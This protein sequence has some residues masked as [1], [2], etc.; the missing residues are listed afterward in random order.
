VPRELST[1]DS[2]ASLS[3]AAAAV[4]VFVAAGAVLMLE[5]LAARLMAP[6]VG[7]SLNTYTG[8]IGTVLGGIAVGAWIGGRMADRIPP[9][10]LLSPIL[11]IG[12]L[13]VMTAAPLVTAFGEHLHSASLKAIIALSAVTVLLPALV[14]STVTPIVVKMQLRD[15]STTG[16]VVGRLS[17]FA[18]AG[19]LVGTFGTGFILAERVH[20]R[21]TLTSAG[22]VLVVLGAVVAWR[23]TRHLVRPVAVILVVGAAAAAAGAAAA[24]HGPCKVESGYFCIWVQ[25]GSPDSRRTL[26]LD[27]LTHSSVDVDDPRYLGLPYTRVLVG[28]VGARAGSERPLTMLHIGGGAFAV[29]RYFAATRRGSINNVIEIDPAVVDTARSDFGVRTGPRLRVAVGDA[30]VLIRRERHGT[31]DFVIGDAFSSRSA[32]WHLTTEQFLRQVRALLRPD[33]TY[34]MN[35]IDRRARFVRAEAATL[36]K[37]FP[38]VALLELPGSDNHV[39]M[40]ATTPIDAA[41]VS[42]ASAKLGVPI[43]VVEEAALRQLIGDAKPLEDDFAPVDQLLQR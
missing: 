28:A 4:V 10:R 17:G 38:H 11:I 40:G 30:R 34:L 37:V 41:A 9:R 16:R 6:Y 29:P 36:Q 2:A 21:V 12:G 26:M 7:V 22:A 5:I 31:Y 33:G 23:L 19:A 35:V 18:T 27:D 25:S 20:T 14:L 15:L 8:I 32:P 39:L 3:S 13:L 24:V 42:S 43:R 1:S